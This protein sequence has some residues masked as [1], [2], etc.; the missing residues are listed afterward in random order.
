MAVPISKIKN[1]LE[2]QLK[3]HPFLNSAAEGGRCTVFMTIIIIYHG[4]HALRRGDSR[5]GGGPTENFWTAAFANGD[6]RPNGLQCV[7]RVSVVRS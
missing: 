6:S 3:N 7:A 4:I 1:K 5:G 2:V